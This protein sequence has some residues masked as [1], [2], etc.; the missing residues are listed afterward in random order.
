M[1]IRALQYLLAIADERNV[2]RAAA[3]VHIEQAPL[4]LAMKRLEKEL[5]FQLYVRSAGGVSLTEA[6]EHFCVYAREAVKS[7]EDGIAI[8]ALAQ[9]GLVGRLRIGYVSSATYF[10]LPRILRAFREEFPNIVINL[11][12]MATNEQFQQLSTDD[13]DFGFARSA[14]ETLTLGQNVIATEPFICAI[15]KG[16]PLSKKTRLHIDD[17]KGQPLIMLP[18]RSGTGTYQQLSNVFARAGYR[19]TVVQ[20]VSQL[21]ASIGLVSSG[22]GIAIVPSSLRCMAVPGVL[23]RQLTGIQ[24]LAEFHLIWNKEKLTAAG[25]HF[26]AI[27]TK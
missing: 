22:I 7:L 19:P 26:L 23:Y 8:A 4:T 11:R 18:P 24:T 10:L 25:K 9:H 6:G 14:D 27:A 3:R 21:E 15:P 13:L 1:N 5:G 17:L 16:H 12:Q 20:E 2:T